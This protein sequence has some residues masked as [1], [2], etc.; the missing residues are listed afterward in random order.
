MHKILEPTSYS[1]EG[2]QQP[3]EQGT[4]QTEFIGVVNVKS[5]SAGSDASRSLAVPEELVLPASAAAT[6]LTV[7][8]GYSFLP[9]AWG[10]GYAT[11]SVEA[12]FEACRRAQSFWAPFPKVYVRSIVHEGNAASLRVMEKTG[13]AKRGIYEWTGEAIFHGGEW[14]PENSLHIFGMYLLG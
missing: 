9:T 2:E 14:R 13:M 1:V 6:T 12:T 3:L 5:V 11:E 10:K 4:K 7:E 8:V